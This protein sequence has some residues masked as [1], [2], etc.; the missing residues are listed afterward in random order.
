[1]HRAALFP[2]PED[3]AGPLFE[4]MDRLCSVA[5]LVRLHRDRLLSVLT[6]SPPRKSRRFGC[7]ERCC[8]GWSKDGTEIWVQGL[9]KAENQPTGNVDHP[10]GGV[11]KPSLAATSILASSRSAWMFRLAASS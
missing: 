7:A 11:E 10:T 3:M 1:M 9:N 6:A 4:V 8:G 2:D 5:P